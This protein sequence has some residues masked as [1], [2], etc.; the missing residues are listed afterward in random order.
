[1][2]IGTSLTVT[3]LANLGGLNVSGASSLN[4]VNAQSL[5]TVGNVGVGGSI[6][7]VSAGIFGS[8]GAS[9][10]S[11]SGNTTLSTLTTSGNTGI[12]GSASITGLTYALGGLRVNG[13]SD[14]TG[15]VGIGGSAVFNSLSTFLSSILG[16]DGSATAPGY[17]FNLDTDTGI[18]RPGTNAL[19]LATG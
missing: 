4:N 15:N 17:S 5:T 3:S 19:G 12:G 13:F 18:F 8:L 1:M 2:G 6:N 7:T 9:A 14:L 16:T 11:V 10:L